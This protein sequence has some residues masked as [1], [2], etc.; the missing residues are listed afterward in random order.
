MAVKEYF[1]QV[2]PATYY[3]VALS[4]SILTFIS[5]MSLTIWHIRALHHKLKEANFKQ[6]PS[7]IISIAFCIYCVICIIVWAA[8]IIDPFESTF[9]C[10]FTRIVSVNMYP[11]FKIFQS[12]MLTLRLH[13]VYGLSALGY[14]SKVLMVWGTFLIIWGAF[15]IIIQPITSTTELDANAV[16]KCIVFVH[17]V[18]VLSVI[19]FDICSGIGNCYL[20]IKPIYKLRELNLRDNTKLKRLATKQMV[21]C[22]VTITSSIIAVMGIGLLDFPQVFG[23]CDIVISTLCIILMYK[24][25]NSTYERLFCCCLS[26]VIEPQRLDSMHRTST[27]SPAETASDTCA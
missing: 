26:D 6:K 25:N 1:I 13:E 2:S 16:P 7:M 21:L 18:F 3:L 4:F 27:A 12:V 19:G 23:G 15:T 14:N 9:F 20:F 10:D 8:P 11:L 17:N 24:W 22:I 5:A